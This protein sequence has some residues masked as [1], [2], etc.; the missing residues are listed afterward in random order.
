MEIDPIANLAASMADMSQ[1]LMKMTD[2][3]L[4]LEDKMLRVAGEEAAA[5][6]AAGSVDVMA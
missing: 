3:K 6:L 4:A 5:S 1:T 2:A